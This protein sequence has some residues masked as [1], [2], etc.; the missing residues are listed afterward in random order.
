MQLI[1]TPW[2]TQLR[3]ILKT[4]EE[5]KSQKLLSGWDRASTR[6]EVSLPVGPEAAGATG[7]SSKWELSRAN[8]P[9][10]DNSSAIS[11]KLHLQVHDGIHR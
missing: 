9:L 3:A 1:S 5:R 11:L 6:T 2:R 7:A 8:K 10:T 4:K